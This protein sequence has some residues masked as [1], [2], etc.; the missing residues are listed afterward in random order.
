MLN[1]LSRHPTNNRGS[2]TTNDFE[3]PLT[4]GTAGY[5]GRIG[6]R[7]SFPRDCLTTSEEKRS[8]TS[9]TASCRSLSD[10][11]L[12]HSDTWVWVKWVFLLLLLIFIRQMRRIPS[13][14]VFSIRRRRRTIFGHVSNSLTNSAFSFLFTEPALLR[15]DKNKRKPNGSVPWQKRLHPRTSAPKFSRDKVTMKRCPDENVSI[16]Q[17]EVFSKHSRHAWFSLSTF[18]DLRR[19]VFEWVI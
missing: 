1:P 17:W 14:G 19:G 9:V 12:I 4:A 2:G 8:Q 3:T 16:F 6:V 10:S 18:H 15:F 11:P 13:P 5:I 7:N